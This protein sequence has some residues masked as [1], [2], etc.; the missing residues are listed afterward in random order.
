MAKRFETMRRLHQNID[1][2]LPALDIH[3]TCH[4]ASAVSSGSILSQR[5][6][7]GESVVSRVIKEWVA[8]LKGCL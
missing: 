1:P 3:C 2:G 5:E 6:V 8:T 7:K 4:L